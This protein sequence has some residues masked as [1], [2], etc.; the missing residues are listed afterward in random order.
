MGATNCPETPRQKMIGMMY[1]VLTAMLALNVSKD[2]IEAFSLVDDTMVSSTANTVAKNES[3]YSWLEGQ[4][5]ILGAEKVKDAEQKAMVLKQKTDALINEIEEIKKGLIIYVDNTYEDKEGKPKTVATI[6]S[7]DERSKPTQFMI[8]Q[9]NATKMKEAIIKYKAEILSLVDDPNQ[10]EAM[11]KTIGLNVEQ[12]FKGKE[13]ATTQSWE[14]HNFYDVIMSAAVTLINTTEGE[15]RNAESKMLE[16]V[17]NSISASD[18]KFDNVSGRAIPNSRMV[19]TGDKY[20]AD[21]IVSAYDTKSTP[22]VYYKTGVDTLTV[23]Q[24]GSATKLEGENGLVRLEL[25]AGGVGEQRYAGL[26]KIKAPDGTD[27]YYSFND[28][29][30]VVKPSATISAEKMNVL[31]A[32]IANPVSVSAPVAPDQLSVNF[33][34]CGVTRAEAGKFNISVPASLIGKTV[35]AT[36]SANLGGKTQAMGSTTFRVK[37]VPDPRATIGANIRGGKRSK[38]ELTANPFIR[39]AMGDDFAYDLKWTINSYQ[40]I[41]ISK[42]YEDNPLTCTGATFSDAVKQKIAKSGS[43]TTIIFTGI[44][45]SCEAG[46]RTLDEITVRIK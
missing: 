24:L 16:Y 23:D 42:G 32:G 10:R 21:I 22:E 20:T 41:F 25:G 19:F 4:K 1:L 13:G 17:K 39:A 18:F 31:Y 14:E 38:N 12:T 15:V 3:D 45:A 2:I 26:I 27:Q 33:P 6:Q 40:V 43:G 11:S 8:E 35:E 36:V 44:K 30:M 5:A 28:R 46:Q 34:G 7:K 29:Y 37:R 9:K